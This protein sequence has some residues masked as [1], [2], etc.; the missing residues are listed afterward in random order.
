MGNYLLLS[1]FN[2][3]VVHVAAAMTT[4]GKAEA[5][6]ALEQLKQL[7]LSSDTAGNS[8]S[9]SFPP[10]VLCCFNC[11]NSHFMLAKRGHDKV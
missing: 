10:Y 3:I 6:A 8:H 7:E 9:V 4:A 11:L 2:L 1:S 5:A